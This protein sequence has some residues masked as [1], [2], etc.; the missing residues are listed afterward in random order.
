MMAAEGVTPVLIED[1]PPALP[2]AEVIAEYLDETRGLGLG[3]AASCRRIPRGGRR[4][5]G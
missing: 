1:H 3:A 2:G 5:A 4:R